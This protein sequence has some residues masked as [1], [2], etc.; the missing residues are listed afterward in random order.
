MVAAGV[1][2]VLGAAA[3]FMHPATPADGT[4]TPERNGTPLPSAVFALLFG[5]YTL[6]GIGYIIAGTFLLAAITL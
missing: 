3:W 5:S 2:A 1:T 4:K 6:E